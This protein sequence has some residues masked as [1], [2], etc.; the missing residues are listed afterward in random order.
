MHKGFQVQLRT[1]EQPLPLIFYPIY[2]LNWK[3]EQQRSK[4]VLYWNILWDE[5]LARALKQRKHPTSVF[6]LPWYYPLDQ[7]WDQLLQVPRLMHKASRSRMECHFLELN[8]HPIATLIAVSKWCKIPFL[9]TSSAS[10]YVVKTV[11]QFVNCTRDIQGNCMCKYH[12]SDHQMYPIFNIKKVYNLPQT[13]T[14]LV[15]T[16][17]YVEDARHI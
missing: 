6:S 1:C 16:N 8:P 13:L 15:N 14:F 11:R 2:A 17:K 9:N 10:G 7:R 3:N 4:M 5:Y 12:Y